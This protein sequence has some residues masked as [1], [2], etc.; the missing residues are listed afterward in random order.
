M[1]ISDIGAQYV[2][3]AY[4]NVEKTTNCSVI[5]DYCYRSLLLRQQHEHEQFL[6]S[7]DY[8]YNMMKANYLSVICINII[9]YNGELLSQQRKFKQII[10]NKYID[11]K[12]IHSVQIEKFKHYFLIPIEKLKKES[13]E[14]WVDIVTNSYLI[15]THP[16]T[17]F[18]K[19]VHSSNICFMAKEL[20]MKAQSETCFFPLFILHF[21]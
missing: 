10:I 18:S 17:I 1:N 7:C 4:S 8:H 19:S 13:I 12:K 2:R 15:L 6:S 21:L 14:I 5:I 20:A 3:S 11:L 16:D 9:K